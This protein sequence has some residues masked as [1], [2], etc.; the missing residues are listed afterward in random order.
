MLIKTWQLGFKS[1][2]LHPM[3]SILTVLGIFIGVASVIWLLAIGAGIS[4]KAQDQ[5]E[6]LGAE[7]IIIRS[8]EPPP[9]SSEDEVLSYGITRAEQ[10][11]LSAIPTVFAS[12]PIRELS[13]QFV[14]SH[15]HNIKPIEGRLV[16]C[17]PEYQQANRLVVR[18]GHFLTDA[19]SEAG[20]CVIAGHLAKKL[21]PLSDPIGKTITLPNKSQRFKVVGVL[22]HREATAA[23]GGSFSGQDFSLDVYIPIRAM[24]TRLGD[25]DMRETPGSFSAKMFQISQCTLRVNSIA[26]VQKTARLAENTLR[27]DDPERQDFSVVVPYELLEQAKTTKLMFMI[28]MGLIAA[29]SLIVGGIGIMNIMLAT[30]TERTREIGIRRALGANRGDIIRQFLIE[31]ILLSAWGG[32]TGVLGGV[33]CPAIIKGANVAVA[34]LLPKLYS[35]LPEVA[36]QLEPV[37]VPASIPIAFGISVTVGI[38]FGLYPARRAALLDPIEALRHQ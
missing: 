29:I 5:I 37:V 31:T 35:Q 1:L 26:D 17:T 12:V 25:L 8:I 13:A 19:E 33:L 15:G 22:H 4:K 2:L 21:F 16:G 36:T 24:E 23:I 30:V 34:N 6:S 10:K 18:R 32:V 9:G 27:R 38:M 7:N 11:L 20:V 28:F 14:N 3:R